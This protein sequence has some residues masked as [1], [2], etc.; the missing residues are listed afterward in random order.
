M[1]YYRSDDR[2]LEGHDNDLHVFMGGNGDWYVSIVKHGERFGPSVRLTTSGTPRG[3][4]HVP[5]AM[6]GL[7]RAL[8]GENWCKAC[9]IEAEIGTEEEP[10]PIPDHFH[11]CSPLETGR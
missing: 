4:E 2:D 11:T 8:G 6:M 3:F 5:A 1:R 10:H 7:Y 9:S